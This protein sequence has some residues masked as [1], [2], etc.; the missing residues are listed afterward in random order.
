MYYVLDPDYTKYMDIQQRINL[1]ILERFGS[2]SVK[3]AFP[4]RT[5]YHE[6][7]AVKDLAVG[8]QGGAA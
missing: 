5:L 1:A 8:P 3:F 2:E 6:G 7:P 4:S